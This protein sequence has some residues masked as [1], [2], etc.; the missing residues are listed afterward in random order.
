M[1]TKN[2]FVA[3]SIAVFVV[4]LAVVLYLTSSEEF[5]LVGTSPETG[6]TIDGFNPVIEF[7]FSEELGEAPAYESSPTIN[8]ESHVE[9]NTLYLTPE[10]ELLEDTRYT[11]RLGTV[12]A[13]SGATLEDATLTFSTGLNSSPKAEFIRS[14]PVYRDGY[15]I[16]Y[17]ERSDA[18]VVQITQEPA[19]R[20]REHARE[21]LQD[22]GINEEEETIQ[23][24]VMRSLRG[25]GSPPG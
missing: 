11:V 20:Y 15:N 5:E 19:Q 14:L 4:L 9:R 18:F 6:E 17:T 13:A 16:T 21:Y 8:A 10:H 25:S 23:F 12:E 7:E 3:I 2:S 1:H 22:N 24:E